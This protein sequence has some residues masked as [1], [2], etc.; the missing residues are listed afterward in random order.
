MPY[1]NCKICKKEFYA[2][3]RHLKI[4]W[5]KY[6]SIKCRTKSQFKGKYLKC[7]YCGKT[8]YRTPRN[9]R[10]SSS[11]KYF[12]SKSCHCSWENKNRRVGNFHTNWKNRESVYR[13]IMKRHKIEKKCIKCGFNDSRALVVHHKDGNRKN[14][15]INNLVWMCRNCHYIKHN[16]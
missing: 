4:G 1:V 9:L 5:G 2:K 15:N 16:F 7:D 13:D 3:P 11:K 12:C 10:K 8:I 14:N 6:C